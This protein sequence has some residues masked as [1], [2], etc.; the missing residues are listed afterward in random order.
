MK[1]VHGALPSIDG[2]GFPWQGSSMRQRLQTV[3][4]TGMSGSGKSTA[5]KAFEDMGYFCVDNLPLA[6]LPDFLKIQEDSPQAP[7]RVALV[8]DVREGTFLDQYHPVFD[9]LR[10]KGF[11]LEV[12]FL[13]ARDEVLIRR[14]HQTRRRHPLDQGGGPLEGVERERTQ[15]GGLKEYADRV[16]DTSDLNVHQL[17][18]SLKEL[19]APRKDLD[20]LML[21]ILSFGFKYGVP[22]EAN[23]VFDVRF[24]PNPY[25]EDHLRALSGTSSRIQSYVLDNSTAREF[26]D[27]VEGLLAFLIP[28]YRQ[29]GK[30]YLVVGVGC[31]GGR[32][33]SVSVVEHLREVFTREGQ[34]VIVTHRDKELER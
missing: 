34:P 2:T 12:L 25:F 17:R 33:R 4:I 32:H 30:S 8:M 16:L 5:L 19:Y 21:H 22:A 23:L 9:G 26:L 27:H 14:F 6:L 15:M 18:H 31:T 28:R 13:D 10:E 29:E 3:V 11:H 7:G 24:L 20:S 1:G